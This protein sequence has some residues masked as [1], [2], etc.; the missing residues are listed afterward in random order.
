MLGLKDTILGKNLNRVE[1]DEERNE[2]AYTKSI[3]FLDD[4]SLSL[5]MKETLR[6]LCDNYAGNGKPRIIS[7]YTKLT[8]L[9]K[10][11]NESVTD[12]Y[13]NRSN[14]NGIKKCWGIIKK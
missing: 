1:T 5:I 2:E 14:V 13:K 3:Q 12:C 7:L 11:P 10:E 6:M 8:T 4:K 9:K